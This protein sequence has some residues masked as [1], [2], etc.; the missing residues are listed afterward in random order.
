VKVLLLWPAADYSTKDVAVGIRKGLIEAGVEVVDYRLSN[1]LDL[2]LRALTKPAKEGG[3]PVAPD[4]VNVALLASEALPFQAAMHGVDWVLGVH[5]VG[6]HPAALVALRRIGVRIAWWFTEAPYESNADRELH[7]ASHVDVAFVNERTSVPLFQSVIDQHHPGGVAHYLRHAYDPATHHPR[8]GADLSENERCDVLFVGTGFAERQ[9]L[10][11]CCDWSGIKLHLGGLWLGV[12]PNYRLFENI[13]YPPIQN[14]ELVRLYAGAKIVVNSHRDGGNAESAN[15]RVW[16]AAACGAFQISDYRQEIVDVLGD[17]VPTY[18]P[19]VPWQFITQV[20]RF[21]ADE[22]A[23]RRLAALALDRVQGETFR[24]RARTVVDAL[25]EFERRSN[26]S[27][28]VAA[29]G[30]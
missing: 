14:A 17:A 23:R 6:L 30:G 22:P 20:R 13:K 27:R 19:G 26:T 10:F 16:E 29:M 5:G 18:A 9:H 1:R 3:E 24:A 11:E 21:L 4:P 8:D 15:P 25:E 28:S 2:A 7:F 12:H